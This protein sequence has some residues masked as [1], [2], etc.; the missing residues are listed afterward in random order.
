MKDISLHRHCSFS[1]RHRCPPIHGLDSRL[2]VVGIQ[3]SDGS[4]NPA[5]HAH[6]SPDGT[7]NRLGNR[8]LVCQIS[9]QKIVAKYQ[10]PFDRI[11]AMQAIQPALPL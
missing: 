4:L 1:Q 9:A 6:A 7:A 11:N 10:E 8:M 5:N 3:R 2:N